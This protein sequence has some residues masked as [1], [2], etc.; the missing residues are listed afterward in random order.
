MIDQIFHAVLAPWIIGTI[1]AGLMIATWLIAFHWHRRRIE[2]GRLREGEGGVLMDEAC[3][4]ILGLLLAFT[5][6]AAYSKYDNRNSKVADDANALRS[7]HFRCELL[8]DVWQKQLV[9]LAREAVEQRLL[10]LKP[11]NVNPTGAR[12]LNEKAN[13]TESQ[14]LA[15]VKRINLDKDASSLAGPVADA[16]NAVAGTHQAR[17]DAARDH[18]PL[19]VVALLLLVASISAF[20]LGRAQAF[21]GRLRKTT[22]SLI[23]LVA[24]IILVTF[25]LESPLR[26]LIMTDQAPIIRLAANLGIAP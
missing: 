8:P 6:A 22:I 16:V 14:M 18:V 20:Q 9:P 10:I 4:A 17:I 12:T 24:A 26:G 19:P 5:F 25:D 13:S 21:S 11:E 23:L 1:C 2:S 15:I 3:L 7:L